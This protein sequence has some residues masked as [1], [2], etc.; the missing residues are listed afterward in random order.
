MQ[1]SCV[2]KGKKVHSYVLSKQFKPSAFLHEFMGTVFET[3]K[4][5]MS[6]VIVNI[7][8]TFFPVKA[9]I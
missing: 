6:F 8:S 7:T 3:K 1:F 4:K 5:F 2:L 9:Q